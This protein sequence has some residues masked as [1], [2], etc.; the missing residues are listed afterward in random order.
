MPGIFRRLRLPHP[1][2]TIHLEKKMGK[3]DFQ[4]EPNLTESE[5]GGGSVS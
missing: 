3:R 4:R 1:F 2:A 5:E